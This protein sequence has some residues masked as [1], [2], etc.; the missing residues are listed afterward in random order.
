MRTDAD[1]KQDVE[2][3]L[4]WDV[5]LSDPAD[6]AIA[7]NDGVV[8]LSGYTHSWSDRHFAERAAKRVN[9]VRGVANDIVVRL[10]MLDQR[11][12]PE[13]ARDAVAAIKQT[14]PLASED[15]KVIVKDGELTLEGTAEWNYQRD[16][17]EKAVRDIKGVRQVRNSVRVK[18]TL[19][20]ADLKKKIEE[21]FVRSAEVDSARITV[22]ANGSEVT[23]RGAV[24]SFA[25]RSQAERSAWAAPGVTKVENKIT[26]APAL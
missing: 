18:P 8:A 24:K 22:E 9:G 12:D 7:V 25:E 23:L 10:R 15:I 4:K 17:A 1:I 2:K 3:E 6:I 16:L 19:S 11:T 13:I 14:I 20:A 26:I 21:A 5:S